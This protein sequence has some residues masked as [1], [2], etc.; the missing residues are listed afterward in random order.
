MNVLLALFRWR[1]AIRGH[2]AQHVGRS[3]VCIYPYSLY[4]WNRWASFSLRE[5]N[6]YSEKWW[7]QV[8][9]RCIVDIKNLLKSQFF[10]VVASGNPLSVG[11]SARLSV[12]CRCVHGA[13]IRHWI[14][15]NETKRS[16]RNAVTVLQSYVVMFDLRLIWIECLN[17]SLVNVWHL[18][19]YRFNLSLHISDKFCVFSFLNS[20]R[21]D[22]ISYITVVFMVD[23]F[24]ILTKFLST[25]N[26]ITN[27]CEI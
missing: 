23:F 21:S 22:H 11:R 17:V 4:L 12:L 5:Y 9:Y 18:Y 13:L 8:A 6:S 14:Q 2:I 7:L 16:L 3:F 27:H 25:Q 1:C 20:L 24:F 26:P 10:G 19:E 15:A